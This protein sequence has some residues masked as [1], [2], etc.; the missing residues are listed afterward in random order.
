MYSSIHPSI[1]PST[2]P[3]IYPPIHPSIYPLTNP[4][5]HWLTHSPIQSSIYHLFIHHSLICSFNKCLWGAGVKRK[6]VCSLIRFNAPHVSVWL[7]CDCVYVHTFVYKCNCVSLC[8]WL[9]HLWNGPILWVSPKTLGETWLTKNDS[10]A[11]L[12]GLDL[13]TLSAVEIKA[14][15]TAYSGYHWSLHVPLTLWVTVITR[16]NTVWVCTNLKTPL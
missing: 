15:L 8:M 1:H 2:T 13:T 3:P 10:N 4:P 9:C 16:N 12:S 5:T 14:C 6:E 11:S 7:F